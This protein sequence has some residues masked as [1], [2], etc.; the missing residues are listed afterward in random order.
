MQFHFPFIVV[1]IIKII[2]DINSLIIYYIT[3]ACFYIALFGIYTFCKAL[4]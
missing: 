3:V 1:N 2:Q 4:Y